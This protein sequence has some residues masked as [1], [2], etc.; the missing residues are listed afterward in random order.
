MFMVVAASRSFSDADVRVADLLISKGLNEFGTKQAAYAAARWV[1]KTLKVQ[2]AVIS[3][4]EQDMS[5]P[6]GTYSALVA[7]VRAESY[8]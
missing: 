2:T 4:V 7:E 8:A 5:D 6:D 3:V 1:A